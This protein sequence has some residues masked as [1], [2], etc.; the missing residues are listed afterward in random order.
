MFGRDVGIVSALFLASSP[1]FWF[2]GEVAL[3]HALDAFAVIASVLLLHR[4]ASGESRLLVPAAIWLGIAGGLRPQTQVFLAPL[5]LYA[6]ARAGWRA[7]LAAAVTLAVA[8]LLWFVPLVQLSGGLDRYLGILAHFRQEFRDT[9][10]VFG[11]GMFGLQR[12]GIKLGMYTAYGWSL[13][14]LPA[15]LG[16]AAALR[17][18]GS[19]GLVRLIGDRR[20]W[21]MALWVVPSFAFYLLIHMGQQG[22]VFVF[23]PALCV[24]SALGARTLFSGWRNGAQLAAVALVVAGNAAI[25]CLAPTFPLGGDRPKLLTV[26][27]LRRHDQAYQHRFAAIRRRFDP[28]HAVIVAASWRFVQFYMPE[29][30]YTPYRLASRWERGE[31]TPLATESIDLAGSQLGISPDAAGRRYAILFDRELDPYLASEAR[32]ETVEVDGDTGLTV[33]ILQADEALHLGPEGIAVSRSRELA[34]P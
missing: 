24:L 11:A 8:D 13:A 14:L 16:A 9:T 5:A 19:A 4:A 32:R 27:T 29:F 10:S 23:L 26:D 12:N 1:L 3:P 2:Y 7:A 25:F 34:A 21:E 17:L 15:V 31:G 18:L 6:A 30:R 28:R 33:V 22:L 20:T